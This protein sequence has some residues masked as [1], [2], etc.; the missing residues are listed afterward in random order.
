MG[1]LPFASEQEAAYLLLQLLYRPGQRRLAHIAALGCAREIQRF[2]HSQEIADLVKLHHFQPSV[3]RLLNESV[4][5]I[6]PG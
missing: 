2:A 4:C 5:E 3:A 6:L 1:E